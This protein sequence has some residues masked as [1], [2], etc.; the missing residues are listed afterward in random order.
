MLQLEE[1]FIQSF[2][3]HKLIKCLWCSSN[4]EGEDRR[5]P[6][7]DIRNACWIAKNKPLYQAFGRKHEKRLIFSLQEVHSLQIANFCFLTCRF[8]LG[9]LKRYWMWLAVKKNCILPQHLGTHTLL[10][11]HCNFYVIL[12]YLLHFTIFYFKMVVVTK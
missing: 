3:K 2:K 6:S 12:L 1:V 5:V 9:V 7:R 4:Y 11:L 8:I 10:K